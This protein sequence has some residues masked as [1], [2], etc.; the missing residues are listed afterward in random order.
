MDEGWNGEIWKALRFGSVPSSSQWESVTSASLWAKP[1][2]HPVLHF[3]FTY[4]HDP[5]ITEPP[6][7]G[8]SHPELQHSFI[9]Q[10][11]LKDVRH[12]SADRRPSSHLAGK[13]VYTDAI[14]VFKTSHFKLDGGRDSVKEDRKQERSSGIL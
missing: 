11:K 14:L 13:S 2:V 1:H 5:E 8:F 10:L 3:P 4:D 6:S 7:T 12:G 9:F